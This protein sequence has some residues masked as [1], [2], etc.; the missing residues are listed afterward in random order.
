VDSFPKSSW[1]FIPIGLTI[2][3]VKNFRPNLTTF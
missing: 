2:D 3:L 1:A